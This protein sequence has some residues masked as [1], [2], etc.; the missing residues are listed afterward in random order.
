MGILQNA[1]NQAPVPPV[2]QPIELQAFVEENAAHRRLHTALD[3]DHP[4]LVFYKISKKFS[5]LTTSAMK[6][7]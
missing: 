1:L 2:I 5:G 6:I 4:N 3:V 7:T